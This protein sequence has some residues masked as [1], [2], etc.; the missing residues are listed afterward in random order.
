MK[1]I[2]FPCSECRHKATTKQSLVVHIQSVHEGLK[3]PCNMCD[4]KAT[5][6]GHLM[7]HKKN[8][9]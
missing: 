1:R 6:K 7:T 3:F 8:K 4:F 9:H 2:K 5:T